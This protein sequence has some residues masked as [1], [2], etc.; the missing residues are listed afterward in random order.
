MVGRSVLAFGV[1]VGSTNT[2]FVAVRIDSGGLEE[3]TVSAVPTP[4]DA[5]ALVTVLDRGLRG[6]TAATGEPHVVGIASMAES[7]VALG[8]DGAALT[9]IL[10][11]DG[12]VDAAAVDDA[13]AGDHPEV[14]YARTGISASPKVPLVMWAQLRRCRPDLD[15]RTWLA[16]A[17]L[18]AFSLTGRALTDHTLAVRTMAVLRPSALPPED[19]RF[20]DD[21][22]AR[23]G[24]R[25]SQLP[26]I[27]GPD[28][29]GSAADTMAGAPGGLPA[30][31]PVVVAGHDH[32][33]AAW[34]CGAREAGDLVDS[35]GTSEALVRLLRGP[36]VPGG[37]FADGMSAGIDVT[38]RFSTLISG[39]ASAGRAVAEVASRAGIPFADLD[40]GDD[41]GH[42]VDR[43]PADPH[44]A[45]EIVLPYLA[46]RQ[47]PHPD[48]AARFEVV[49]GDP[50]RVR[51]PD[52]TRL[53]PATLDGIALHAAWARHALDRVVGGPPGRG[54]S[55]PELRDRRAPGVSTD[56][57]VVACG[58]VAR[59]P[60][61]LLRKAAS[62]GCAVRV[63][64]VAEPVA[65]SAA[66]LA[67]YRAL[68]SPA[69]VLPLAPPLRATPSAAAAY[70]AALDR[71]VAAAVRVGSAVP[72]RTA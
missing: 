22:L 21:L 12:S 64:E 17:D 46:G 28:D 72:E 66:V 33:V 47:S 55:D 26:E 44:P 61:L 16:M 41:V 27:V 70:A 45:V 36:A 29:W 38:G 4:G 8:R 63:P 15:L 54:P 52:W 40:P 53:L 24:L 51:D 39:S 56:G 9:P 59:R 31:I 60:A 10:R 32:L 68:G 37:A 62:F 69:H 23:V 58:P 6:L 1:D 48:P 19:L 30:G 11:W 49:G 5:A 67:A 13:L 57:V 14:L 43:F 71:F 20:D 34:G 35:F 18:V 25:T 42:P 3:L 7:G 65:S 2:K 50:A